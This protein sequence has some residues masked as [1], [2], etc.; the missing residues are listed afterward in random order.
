M[1]VTDKWTSTAL[2]VVCSLVAPNIDLVELLVKSGAQLV[3]PGERI[4]A[5]AIATVNGHMNIVQCL[6]S[7]GAPVDAPNEDGV[8][9]LMCTCRSNRSEIAHFLLSHGA[10]P[11]I[12]DQNNSTVY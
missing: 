11:N 1:Q 8:T 3:I 9:S 2:K 6:V 12:Q 4:T 7:A 10:D 5:L